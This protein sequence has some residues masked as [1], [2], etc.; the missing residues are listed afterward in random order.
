MSACPLIATELLSYGNRHFEPAA[1]SRL[2][3]V[4]GNFDCGIRPEARAVDRMMLRVPM[5]DAPLDLAE[6]VEATLLRQV[7]EVADQVCD[8]MLI[9]GVAVSLKYGDG[10]GSP[11]NVVGFIGHASHRHHAS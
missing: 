3:L 4:D 8:G 5:P 10:V 11:C 2:T 1:A 7:P 9:A 6:K